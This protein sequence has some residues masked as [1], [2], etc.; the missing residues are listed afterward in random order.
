MCI[1]DSIIN[2]TAY[3]FSASQ[4]DRFGTTYTFISTSGNDKVILRQR[5]QSLSAFAIID[6]V[7]KQLSVANDKA[8]LTTYNLKHKASDVASSVTV[9]PSP[10]PQWHS[11]RPESTTT[12]R[13]VSEVVSELPDEVGAVFFI[14]AATFVE[15]EAQAA[16][17]DTDTSPMAILE[18]DVA[19][20]NSAV[21][22]AGI[23]NIQAKV[24]NY[25]LVADDA[26][27][28][29]LLGLGRFWEADDVIAKAELGSGDM[30]F[31][32]AVHLTG[33]DEGVFSRPRACLLYTSPS[34][35][36]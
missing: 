24:Q 16:D 26:E 30:D 3:R 15:A 29:E 33:F 32:S 22:E 21:E 35:R 18:Q 31:L 34:P 11:L 4:Q 9:N 25:Y 1:R 23:S 27:L 6:G 28:S 10:S 17:S 20:F 14:S 19:T 13:S 12:K 7:Q 36:D 5:E 8:T 2:D